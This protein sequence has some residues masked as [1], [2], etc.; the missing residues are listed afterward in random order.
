M[1]G[2]GRDFTVRTVGECVFAP[3]H[4]GPL[5]GASRVGEAARGG[6]IV[7]IGVWHTADGVRARFRATACASLVGYA[8]VA[9]EA[10]EAGMPGASL[11]APS[12][13]AR[14]AGVHRA[15]LD[16]A[17]IVAAAVRAAFAGESR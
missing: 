5:D 17:E 4:T 16:R 1:A 9:C 12:L 15:H 11:D 10:L 7:R 8:E 13:A 14:L 2:D 3:A 6:R